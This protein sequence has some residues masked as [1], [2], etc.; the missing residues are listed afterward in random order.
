MRRT[1]RL[2]RLQADFAAALLGGDAGPFAA[3]LAGDPATALA[4][5]AVYRRAIAANRNGALRS[6]YPVAAR[7]VG[8]AFFA[9]A[10]RQYSEAVPPDCGDL[11]R[12]GAAFADFLAAYPHAS[13]MP[14]LPDVARLEWAGHEA[15][16]AADA[17]PFDFAGLAAVPEE[18]QARLAFTL[19]PSVRLER[20]AWPVLAIWEANQPERDGTPDRDA[21]DDDVLVWREDNRVRMAL[22]SA[23]EAGIVAGLANGRPLGELCGPGLAEDF[24]ATLARLAGHGML[25]GFSV[26]T[27]KTDAG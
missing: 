15:L 8:D 18:D 17:P 1:Q 12:H 2:A 25:A 9:E 16:L 26:S 4:R 3:H 24:A 21:G 6:T 22:L 5:L 20:S 19:H 7:I 13:A 14:W 23:T 11:N 10:A 27:G